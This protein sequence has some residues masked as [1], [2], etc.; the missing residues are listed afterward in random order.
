MHCILHC[1]QISMRY[2]NNIEKY[3]MASSQGEEAGIFSHAQRKAHQIKL[4]DKKQQDGLDL[5]PNTE[6]SISG[7]GKKV[8]VTQSQKNN[9]LQR[10]ES[11]KRESQ[12]PPDVKDLAVIVDVDA[13]T[14]IL[15]I[16]G[17]PVPFHL[18]AIRNAN[19]TNDL[20]RADEGGFVYLRINFCFPGR[21]GQSQ[22][23]N[24]ESFEEPKANFMTSVTLRSGEKDRMEF[25]AW[26]ITELRKD[27]IQKEQEKKN[28]VDARK[29]IEVPSMS[30]LQTTGSWLSANADGSRSEASST[31][32]CVCSACHSKPSRSPN[33][34]RT[35]ATSKRCKVL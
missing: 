9:V 34:W 10:I 17:R 35:R 5:Y 18:S 8:A 20:S 33:A 23:H 27:Y 13:W 21:T 7:N 28:L 6:V 26:Q 2:L 19:T 31:L 15:P 16:M 22:K 32:H 14:V 29:L 25:L 4:A 12:L 30:K 24:A 1:Y 3:P 11:Y